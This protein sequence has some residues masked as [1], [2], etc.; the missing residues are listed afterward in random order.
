MS[1]LRRTCV[2]TR[3]TKGAR[4]RPAV[5]DNTLRGVPGTSGKPPSSAPSPLRKQRRM[6][7]GPGMICHSHRVRAHMQRSGQNDL[8]TR[9]RCRPM[10]ATRV[11]VPHTQPGTYLHGERAARDRHVGLGNVQVKQAG[12]GGEQRHRPRGGVQGCTAAHFPLLV[13]CQ[14]H[15]RTMPPRP[16]H[17]PRALQ[18]ST[19]KRRNAHMG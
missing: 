2:H 8:T 13:H 17:A 10:R 1:L 14:A 3:P 19:H 4:T 9:G 5:H 16:T 11:T 18:T 6:S 12:P 15:R 7:I